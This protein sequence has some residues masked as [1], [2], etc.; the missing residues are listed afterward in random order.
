MSNGFKKKK[1]AS[2]PLK[3][4]AREHTATHVTSNTAPHWIHHTRKDE[5]VIGGVV[6]LPQCDCS[7]CGFTVNMEKAVCPHCG[8]IMWKQH[9]KK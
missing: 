1:G 8:A 4:D 5:N 3:K 6:Y 2:I 9:T 7:E